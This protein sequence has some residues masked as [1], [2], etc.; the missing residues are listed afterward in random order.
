MNNNNIPEGF[1]ENGVRSGVGKWEDGIW[2]DIECEDIDTPPILF[3]DE[4]DIKTV[5][6][7]RCGIIVDENDAVS[8]DYGTGHICNRCADEMDIY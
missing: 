5:Q 7:Y 4:D 1:D 8:I 2:S 6:C 3:D